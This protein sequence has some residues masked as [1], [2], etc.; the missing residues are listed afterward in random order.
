MKVAL[1]LIGTI[2]G[3]DGKYGLNQS[4]QVLRLGYHGYKKHLLDKND[5]DVF[6]HT[7]S[8]G[9]KE[10]VLSLYRP[11]NYLFLEEPTFT[12]PRYVTGAS[13]RKR[14]HY[15]RWFSYQVVSD[16]RKKYEEESGTKY[17]F[18]YIGRYDIGWQ[19]DVDFS[20]LDKGKFYSAN[21]NRIYRDGEEL[22]YQDW[23]WDHNFTYL[24]DGELTERQKEK[25]YESKLVGYPH[26]DEGFTDQWF[27][28]NPD[29]MD[30]FCT[31]FKHLDEY[32]KP[33]KSWNKGRSSLVDWC[34][35][36]SNHRLAPAHLEK[37]GLLDKLDFKFY[38]HDDFPL[39]RGMI[40]KRK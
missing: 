15:H 14:A 1:C 9:F 30:S 26:N 3:K 17:D 36:I 32:T 29:Y 21:W 22:N 40:S 20:T 25:G 31:L 12:I 16:L 35:N 10:E 8:L 11:K 24:I 2:G 7:S 39:V 23:F 28:S 19:R 38:Y 34:G 37:I 4:P 13:S 33:N 5:V 6:C 27:I 18:V